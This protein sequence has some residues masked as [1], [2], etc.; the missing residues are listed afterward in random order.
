MSFRS[1]GLRN[2][3][4]SEEECRRLGNA[5][6]RSVQRT[7]MTMGLGHDVSS[8]SRS[9]SSVNGDEQALVDVRD[10]RL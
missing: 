4:P 3:A 1:S 7:G 9:S 6:F 2:V 5:L 10:V 8:S